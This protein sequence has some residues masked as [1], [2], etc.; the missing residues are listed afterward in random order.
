MYKTL[1][2]SLKQSFEK[3][4]TLLD[5]LPIQEYIEKIEEF[6][7]MRESERSTDVENKYKKN[8]ITPTKQKQ[9]QF[10]VIL[11]M[12]QQSGV[13]VLSAEDDT[14]EKINWY[15]GD[16]YTYEEVQKALKGTSVALYKKQLNYL[17]FLI[18]FL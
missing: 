11:N 7:K 10:N 16:T 15:Q 3:K 1:G 18:Q 12:L 13:Y 8:I 14:A 17:L 9:Q 6:K 4:I 5:K 2:E